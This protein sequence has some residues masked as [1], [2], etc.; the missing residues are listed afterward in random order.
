MLIGR[1]LTRWIFNRESFASRLGWLTH[2]SRLCSEN[3]CIVPDREKWKTLEI[4]WFS[5][6]CGRSSDFLVIRLEPLNS[7]AVWWVSVSYQPVS[8]VAH[9]SITLFLQ[10]SA[11]N[12]KSCN[13][14][15]QIL[16]QSPISQTVK[17]TWVHDAWGH[18]FKSNFI[19]LPDAVATALNFGNKSNLLPK[20]SR[21]KIKYILI[22][23]Q[24]SAII[25]AFLQ[26][27]EFKTW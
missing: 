24:K 20:L 1:R 3:R 18:G 26:K 16:S 4:K 12:C 19:F 5:A 10:C 23:V 6:F 11:Q 27:V 8:W 13:A 7:D 2:Y 22:L 9:L 21:T 17:N 14:K 25:T 15:L